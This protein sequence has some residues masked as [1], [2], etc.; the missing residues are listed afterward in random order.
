[1]SAVAWSAV[2]E[3]FL[4]AYQWTQALAGG[5]ALPQAGAPVQLGPGEVTHARVA[6]V[7]ISGFFGED[8]QYRS[9]FFLIG[10][11][12]GLAVTGA[13][14]LAYNASKKADAQRAAVPSW[15]QLGTAEIVVTNQR[16]V[17]T[18]SGRTESLWYAEIGPLQLSPGRGGM[19]GV[20]F[21][22]ADRPMLRLESA[23]APLLYVFVHYLVD[24][25]APG[26][27]MPPG[28]LERAQQQGRLR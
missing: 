20:Q 8:K 26:L 9:S 11:P 24:G 22:P 7:G 5:S 25:Q 13:A 18:G 28:L 6:P 27:P 17:A 10:G 4:N 14:S 3:G 12:V 23:G 15:H 1:V 21:Q 16:L 2:D 19:P